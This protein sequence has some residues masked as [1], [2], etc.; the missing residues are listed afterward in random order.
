MTMIIR[1]ALTAEAD[2]LSE[3]ARTAKKH[4]GYPDHWIQHWRDD[5][6]ISPDYLG[7]NPVY[8]AE[9]D[10]KLVGF[11][12]L[13]VVQDKAVLDHLW[14]TPEHIG[15]GVGKQLF[16]HAMQDAAKRNVTA[17]EIS[18]DPHAEGFYQKMGAH[19]IGTTFSEIDGKPRILP[20]LEVDPRLK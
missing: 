19:R 3:I 6:T 18:S 15:S 7:L 20:Q 13:V 14:V 1:R 2:T 5:L 11:Y 4:W 8:V 16:L 9:D 12:A 17:V 10:G